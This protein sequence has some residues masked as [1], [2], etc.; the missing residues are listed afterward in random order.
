MYLLFFRMNCFLIDLCQKM[1]DIRNYLH[2]RM[3]NNFLGLRK[4]IILHKI[5]KRNFEIQFVSR[6][7]RFNF[8]EITTLEESSED[9]ATFYEFSDLDRHFSTPTD[10]RKVFAKEKPVKSKHQLKT[11]LSVSEETNFSINAERILLR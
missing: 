1:L 8:S 5:R 3:I 11:S 4:L 6:K 9:L 7:K 10:D 2:D